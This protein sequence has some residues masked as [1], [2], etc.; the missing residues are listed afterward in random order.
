MN[1]FS[2]FSRSLPRRLRPG[3]ALCVLALAGITMPPLRAQDFPAVGQAPRATLALAGLKAPVGVYRDTLG[4]P[5]IYAGSAEDAY[6]ALGYLHATD[7]LFEMEVFRRRASGTLAEVFGKASLDDDIFVRQIGIRRSAEAAWKSHRLDG[8]IRSEMEAYCAGVNARLGELQK[9]SGSELPAIFQQLGFTPAP[10]TPVDALAFPKYMGW[11]QSGT[12]TDVWMAMLV[13]KL[14]LETVNELFP[15]DRPYEVPT[16]P[17]WGAVNPGLSKLAARN[18]G[19]AAPTCG[20]PLAFRPMVHPS[21]PAVQPG[22][23]SLPGC[24]EKIEGRGASRK[25]RGFPQG[26]AAE[27]LP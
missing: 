27:P 23:L 3:A 14:G 20:K 18:S 26:R 19:S 8:R 7:R 22:R 17:G 11:D 2:V 12:D 21:T 13:E 6:F 4:I 9:L 5:H 25:A 24:S 15:L 10:W 1:R 16:I